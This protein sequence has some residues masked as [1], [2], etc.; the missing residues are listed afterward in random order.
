MANQP[1]ILYKKGRQFDD[2]LHVCRCRD[3]GSLDWSGDVV[4][5][6]I[7]EDLLRYLKMKSLDV[8]HPPD[9]SAWV[10][11]A[12][13]A[14]RTGDAGCISDLLCE[15]ALPLPCAGRLAAHKKA[16]PGALAVFLCRPDLP[17]DVLCNANAAQPCWL[18]SLRNRA[19]LMLCT[20]FSGKALLFLCSPS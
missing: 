14:L 7:V 20:A 3:T 16:R 15:P 18:R 8:E 17:S 19:F 2:F 4:R 10:V 5:V 13:L 12:E 6:D 9:S 1:C 11:A